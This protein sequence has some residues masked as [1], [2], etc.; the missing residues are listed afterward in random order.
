MSTPV[1][2]S[3]GSSMGVWVF[4]VGVALSRIYDYRRTQL[5]FAL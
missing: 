1:V 3:M 4:L 2:E 5:K